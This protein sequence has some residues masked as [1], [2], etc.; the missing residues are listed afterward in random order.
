[1]GELIILA[2]RRHQHRPAAG[3][4]ALAGDLRDDLAGRDALVSPLPPPYLPLGY[5][6][7]R[8]FG[9]MVGFIAA[10]VLV[11]AVLEA[12]RCGRARGEESPRVHLPT[13]EEQLAALDDLGAR[14]LALRARVQVWEAVVRADQVAKLHHHAA[15]SRRVPPASAQPTTATLA[16]RHRTGPATR[17]SAQG[18]SLPLAAETRIGGRWDAGLQAPAR[19][20][21]S[22]TSFREIPNASRARPAG[23]R[24]R[25][26]AR[27]QAT[28]S[29]GAVPDQTGPRRAL[30]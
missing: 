15:P 14:M 10:A 24:L 16:A 18:G 2:A 20:S 3:R 27:Q 8:A 4:L 23:A 13:L 22:T 5:R 12:A 29:P 6:V 1:M 25:P 28:A 19:P 17:R 30:P 21:S 7:G 11:T 26:S 9:R